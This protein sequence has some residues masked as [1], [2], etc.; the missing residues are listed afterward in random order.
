MDEKDVAE[1]LE[2]TDVLVAEEEFLVVGNYVDN[3]V[4]ELEEDWKGA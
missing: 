3:D 2:L 1:Q 4:S